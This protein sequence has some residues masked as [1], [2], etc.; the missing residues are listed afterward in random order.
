M[1][2]PYSIHFILREA[3]RGLTRARLSS[4]A[5]IGIIAFTLVLL[6]MVGYIFTILD[7]L[8]TEISHQFEIVVYLQDGLK[9][10]EK[11]LLQERLSKIEGVKEVIY[12]SKEEAWKR[13]KESFKGN[14][15]ALDIVGKNPL[16][17]SFEVKLVDPLK[18][19]KMAEIFKDLP[20]VKDVDFPLEAVN[21]FSRFIRWIEYAGGVVT[22]VFIVVALFV[23][24]NVIRLSFVSRLR[25]LEIM[26]LVGASNLFI[27]GPFILEGVICGFFGGIAGTIVLTILLYFLNTYIISSFPLFSIDISIYSLRTSFILIIFGMMVGGI[28]SVLFLERHA[29]G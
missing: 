13:F 19:S 21:K 1:I 25:E 6:G 8:F 27:K 2:R 23:I 11:A 14:K 3:W 20:G 12:V 10:G 7:N 22:L 24:A 26:R 5:A 15:L 17:D 9:E 4:M 28:G 18:S 16:P 29:K